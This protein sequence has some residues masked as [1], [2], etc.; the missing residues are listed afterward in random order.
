[1]KKE[2][3][4]ELAHGLFKLLPGPP[5]MVQIRTTNVWII[6][7]LSAPDKKTG[8]LLYQ[9][10]EERRPHW[11]I[12]SPCYSKT[13]V[14]AAIERA[15]HHAHQSTM[16]PVLHL[17]AHGD[18]DG[19]EG[20]NGT[21]GNER[22]SWDELA[23]PLQGLNLATRCNLLIFIAACTGFAGINVFLRGPRAPAVALVGP[24]SLISESTLFWATKEFYRRCMDPSASLTDMATSA[25]REAGTVEFEPEPFAVL[26]FESM[27]KTLLHGVRRGEWI[28]RLE[29]V[30]LKV[31]SLQLM[32]DQLFMIDLWPENRERFGVDIT[33]VVD[34]LSKTPESIVLLCSEA[35]LSA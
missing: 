13:Q 35:S 26:A 18:A 2:E 33:A 1:M 5:T 24:D 28:R 11:A 22:L 23:E 4:H 9:W 30:R 34:V 17:E 31:S 14:L 6:E 12:Y 16:I 7:W 27:I 15:T 19:L 10:M 8:Q 32:W 25:S 21:G 3:P 29:Q 20:P